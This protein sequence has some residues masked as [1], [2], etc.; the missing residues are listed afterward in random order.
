MAAA[1][2]KKR[3][4]GSAAALSDASARQR[5]A[6]WLKERFFVRF[7]IALILAFAVVVGL[8]TTRGFFALGLETMHWRWPLALL[9]AYAAFLLGVRV[10]L[11]YI[12]LGRYL[13]RETDFDV[14]IPDPGFSVSGGDSGTHISFGD[15]GS[16][17]IDTA[18]SNGGFGGGGASADFSA[19][20]S[21]SG[22]GLAL[23]DIDVDLGGAD[24]GCL[25]LII[26]ALVLALLVAVFGVGAY[27]V[28]QA[29]MLLAEVAFEAALAGGLIRA[30][31]R[32]DDPGWIGGAL[33]A[34]WKPFLLIF[35]FSLA[36]A[37][38]TEKF[39]PEARTL[40]QAIRQLSNN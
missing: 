17:I 39:A 2:D 13:E 26:L 25:P 16:Q 5:L 7:H 40:P 31:R 12:G 32:V 9:A 33:S 10:W 38:L 30:A 11:A 28:W 1:K 19:G 27:V 36:A 34:S 18:G 6:G 14:D 20:V 23:P 3:A 35:V 15:A 8:L 29:P 21:D 24:E 37:A 4:G 22:S